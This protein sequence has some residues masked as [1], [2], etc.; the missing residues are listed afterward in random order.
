MSVLFVEV[1]VWYLLHRH[2]LINFSSNY[3]WLF[4]YNATRIFVET[5]IDVHGLSIIVAVD[6]MSWHFAN[7]CH[8]AERT[9][10]RSLLWLYKVRNHVDIATLTG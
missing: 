5:V 2:V 3:R 7:I 4:S 10:V 1:S 6:R 8:Q 9:R